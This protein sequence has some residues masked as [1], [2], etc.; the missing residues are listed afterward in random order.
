MTSELLSKLI[1]NT[2]NLEPICQSNNDK[3]KITKTNSNHFL[4]KPELN[5]NADKFIPLKEKQR[6][7]NQEIFPFPISNDNP[8]LISP[9]FSHY[10][11]PQRLIPYNN[12]LKKNIRTFIL[13]QNVDINKEE[14][15]EN[16]LKEKY[17]LDIPT[18]EINFKFTCD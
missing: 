1:S 13:S 3:N 5:I 11:N 7:K 16:S 10:I 6:L 18:I 15:L 4:S 2:E 14:K 9:S 8:S 17:N 12:M